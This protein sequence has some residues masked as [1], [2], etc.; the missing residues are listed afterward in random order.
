MIYAIMSALNPAG[1][2]VDTTLKP[3]RKALGLYTYCCYFLGESHRSFI[4]SSHPAAAPA[5]ALG[6]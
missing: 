3:M 5:A 6:V 4:L 2:D 1:R